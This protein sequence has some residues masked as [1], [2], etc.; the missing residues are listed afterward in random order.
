MHIRG[1]NNIYEST[2]LDES[3]ILYN[4]FHYVYHKHIKMDNI[5]PSAS[6]NL[7]KDGYFFIFSFQNIYNYILHSHIRQVDKL[8]NLDN[9]HMSIIKELSMNSY[10]YG[11]FIC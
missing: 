2:Y 5:T 7:P 3:I 10:I 6:S 4:Y 1:G 11:L 9:Q 8:T